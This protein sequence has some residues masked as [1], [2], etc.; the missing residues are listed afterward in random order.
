M[1]FFCCCCL[2]ELFWLFLSLRAL[3]VIPPA[4]SYPP[5]WWSLWNKKDLPTVALPD[6]ISGNCLSPVTLLLSWRLPVPVTSGDTAQRVL[7]RTI[8]T[9]M[10]LDCPAEPKAPQSGY[11]WYFGVKSTVF[12]GQ[13]LGMWQSCRVGGSAPLQ[14]GEEVMGAVQKQQM[15]C[16]LKAHL[17]LKLERLDL[18]RYLLLEASVH[19]GEWVFHF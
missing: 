4:I 15:R 7:V 1:G 18:G 12:I 10:S 8:T 16:H 9:G 14:A 13:I 3:S 11:L 17:K 19:S 5:G 2:V 6:S